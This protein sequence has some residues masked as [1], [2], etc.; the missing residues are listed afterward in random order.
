MN[1]DIFAML[2]QQFQMWNVSHTVNK[3]RFGPDY[4]SAVYQLDGRARV[5]QE[6]SAMYQYYF[7][8]GIVYFCNAVAR[9]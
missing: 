2:M 3:I 4:P 6:V 7:Q 5:I 1:A 8:V 9:E